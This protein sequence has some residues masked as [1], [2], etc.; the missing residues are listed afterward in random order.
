M[1]DNFTCLIKLKTYPI[2]LR[3]LSTAKGGLCTIIKG[4]K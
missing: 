1:E 4:D 2:V 3:I